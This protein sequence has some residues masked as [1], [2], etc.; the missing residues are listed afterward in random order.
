[1]SAIA[2]VGMGCR[3]AGASDLHDYWKLTTDGRDAFGPVPADRWPEAAFYDANR[4]AA[5]KT[6][7]KAGAFMDDIRSFPALML[8]IPPRRVEVMDPQQRL[9]IEVALQA[10][11]DGGY[12]PSQ[13]PRRT[14]VFVG[15]TANEFRMMMGTRVMATMMATGQFG[16]APEDAEALADA[17]ERIVQVRPFTAPGVLANMPS[18]A[19]AQELDLQGPAYTVDAACASALVAVH[20]A[21]MQLRTGTI[22]AALAGGSYLQMTP[23][24]Y[25]A[26]ARIGAMS[27]QGRCLPF[28][29]RADGFVQGDGAGSFLL[30]RLEDA[31]RDGDR[32]YAVIEGVALN[33]DGHG[34]GPMAPVRAGQA[35]VMMDA[36]KDAGAD[37][38][39]LRYIET[40]GT[41][42]SVGDVSEIGAMRDA[43]NGAIH[44]VALG[45]S[46]A[47]VG[48]TMSAAAAAGLA[49]TVLAVH[50]GV[51]PPMAGFE[52]PKEAIELERGDFVIPT[53]ARPWEG[54]RLAALSSFGFG[55]TNGHLVLR[56]YEARR[57]GV[58]ASV[59]TVGASAD[60]VNGV[61]APEQLEIVRFSAGT[62]D[63]LRRTAERLAEELRA[64]PDLTVAEVART[65][66]VRQAVEHRCALVAGTRDELLGLLDEVSRGE[67]PKGANIGEVPRKA[68]KVA[69]L[70]AGQGAQRVGM[71][72][73]VIERF[74]VVDEALQGFE[75][76]LSDIVARPLTHLLYPEKRSEP[77]DA[78][79]AE[80]ELTQTENCQ[81]ALV[82]AGLALH[83]ILEEVGV[84]PVAAAG[85]SLG[86]FAAAAVGGVL[87]KRDA[88]RFAAYRGQAMNAVEGDPGSMAALRCSGE[89]AV[90]FLVE[91]AVVAN[92]N[93]P[94]QVVVS[95][96]TEAVAQVVERA[97]AAGVDAKPLTVSHAFH[98]PIFEQVDGEALVAQVSLQDPSPDVVV[99]S[100]I[101]ASP[102]ASA[103]DA[104]AVFARHQRSPVHFQRALHQLADAGSTIYLQVGAGGPLASFARKVVGRDAQAV[105]S[106]S[107]REDDDGGRAVLEA[108]GR[109]WVEGV[110]LDTTSLTR[111]VQVR[112]LPAQE[113]PREPYWP[114]SDVAQR[115]LNLNAAHRSAVTDEPDLTTN[116]VTNGVTTN[117]AGHVAVET[118]ADG[119]L[120]LDDVFE[121]VADVVAEVSS[122]PRA[123]VR[124]DLSLFDDLGFDSLMV[125][126]LATGL[127][128]V[129]PGL[130]GLP[131]EL[132]M[133]RPTV[134]ALA[135]HIHRNRDAD[136]VDDD[137]PLTS[138]ALHW[139]PA[140]L[141]GPMRSLDGLRVAVVGP[142]EPY[143]AALRIASATVVD[144]PTEPV[145]VVVW[146]ADFEDPVSPAAVAAGE[147]VLPDPAGPLIALLDAHAKKGQQPGV[148]VLARTDD[149]WASGLAGVARTANQ[150]WSGRPSQTLWFAGL[151]A[152]ERAASLVRTL[153]HDDHSP[154]VHFGPQGRFVIGFEPVE[155]PTEGWTPGAADRVLITGGTRGIG[156]A[157]AERLAAEGA[158]VVVVGRKAPEASLG[159][160]ITAV[161]ADVT[162]RQAL[163]AAVAPHRPFTAV[164]HSAGV[165]ADGALGTVEA[166]H[167]AMARRI[168][169]AGLLNALAAAGTEVTVAMALGSWAGRFGNRHQAHYAAANATLAGLSQH[170][171][172]TALRIVTGEYGPWATSEM[173]STIPAAI[174]ATMR[175]EGID[176]VG[177]EAGM[178]A[179]LADLHHGR[180]ALT[181]GRALPYWMRRRTVEHH[182]S[183]E[184]HPYL[185]DHA[186]EGVPILPLASATDLLAQIAGVPAPFEVVDVEL[187]NGITVAEPVTVTASI[188]GEKAELR[189]GPQRR[190]AYQAR[191][192]PAAYP[193]NPSRLSGGAP[194]AT[195]LATFYG[196]V[197]FH[198]PLLQGITQVDGVSDNFARGVV[199]SRSPKDWI[200]GTDRPA[201]AVDPL[202]VDSAFQLGALVVWDRY[203]RAGTPVAVRR[204]VQ[205]A[206]A[207][208]GPLTVEARFDEAE[209]DR[210]VASFWLRDDLGSLVTVI[211]G[212][213]AEMQRDPNAEEAPAAPVPDFVVKDEWVDP[214]KW[215]EIRDLEQ[216]LEM[217]SAV[218]LENPYFHVH[219]GTARDTTLVEGR[220]LVNFSSYNYL[221]LSGDERV[222]EEVNEAV[223]KYGTSV[224]ASRV[225]SGERPF[226]QELE[227]E[228]AEAQGL[229]DALVFTAGHMT[230]VN[231][232]GHLMKPTDLILHDELI[233]DSALQGI[234][235]SGAGRRAFRHEDPEHLDQL[236]TELRPHHEKC[237]IIVEG[238]YSMDG[239]ITNYPAFV[240]LK[241]K[242]GCLLMVDEAHSFGVCGSTGCGV[243][244]HFAGQVT[245]RD[246][247]LWMG[248]LSK[249]LA[250]CGG[251]I[252]GSKEMIRY[253]RYTAPGFVYS[254]GITPANAVAALA[255]LRLMREER[256]RV[257][258]LQSNAKVFHDALVEHGVDTGPA[259]GGSGVVPAVTGHSMHA[260]FLSQRLKEQGINVQP[261]VYPAVA[262]DAARLR[263]F[264]SSTH[265]HEQLRWTAERVAKNLA[266][267]RAEFP[268]APSNPTPASSGSSAHL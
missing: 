232:I 89:R 240:E 95:G 184:T 75:E 152:A 126:D 61:S 107:G 19:V 155:A 2:I 168:K 121:K 258:K 14:G 181:K 267:I 197:T 25:I 9:S 246:A 120:T 66:N 132:L 221:G 112:S 236:L 194:P 189:I 226:H 145:D 176:F 46:K 63:G 255:S 102:Y 77:I 86:E 172:G 188:D 68:P 45:S 191:V 101:A 74:P 175:A 159:E 10:I 243:G 150:E 117:G 1:M 108:L 104:H 144:D 34:D 262:D 206:P 67:F 200:P 185:L 30:K 148:I 160:R 31:E 128:R 48:H 33:N 195:D 136:D 109:L 125:S 98:S 205:V 80:A 17:V 220:E 219:Q 119:E 157:L 92:D 141:E 238:V 29:T 231:V 37:P 106:L 24:H 59:P 186:I 39:E 58:S 143:A 156:R 90:E 88:V 212:T 225:A 70:F 139:R 118:P 54:P 83:R 111:D 180:G 91:G 57:T 53:A 3:Y 179:L 135:E 78:E 178:N 214:S 187:F 253:L 241:R 97:T 8:G 234:K 154:D 161:A 218:G 261:I 173:A 207:A 211:E 13:L 71:L 32:I 169:V 196:D 203:G 249:S 237:L 64:H 123:A 84:K 230:N 190:L 213:V 105:L 4:R 229:D 247:D 217:A 177:D 131:R 244:E 252:A 223:R 198:G 6:Y 170:W 183:T 76:D 73:S 100:G 265:S 202:A 209:G 22:D 263:F 256:W 251:W 27:E 174:Q 239:D 18:A 208:P 268:A 162:D 140:A 52:N 130:G 7:A 79:A 50:H 55:G 151:G 93:H 28:D 228:L 257:E 103:A 38:A 171:P 26:F 113:W 215:A 254:A 201:W 216:R 264:L 133:N 82:A 99:A 56:G 182:L 62:E 96:Y 233:H 12:L 222:I 20:D 94:K 227:R 87:S 51:I 127:S 85:H 137:A 210:F 153:Q 116:G 44:N 35:A 49:R 36:W 16:R 122:Y 224:S 134:Q 142:S 47:N 250:S 72:R 81:P 41:G 248:T 149:P 204:L 245:P 163:V 60:A 129:F 165:L 242:H 124:A 164:V 167:G 147:A 110:D 42:T 23:E 11:A 15:I 138:Y 40:H 65:W 235:L 115:R 266:D 114:I 158:E 259:L 166:E 21:V 146:V 199:Q 193:E 260:L 5:D 192:R 43:F 69:L